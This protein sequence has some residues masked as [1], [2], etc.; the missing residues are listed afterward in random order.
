[1]RIK[2][3]TKDIITVLV[4][5]LIGV[6]FLAYFKIKH[7]ITFINLDEL[8]WMY[9]SR[10]FMDDI[11]KFDFSNLIQFPQPGI[12]VMWLAGPFMK[13]LDYDFSLISNF[14]ESFYKAGVPYNVIND[15][16]PELYL[17]YKEISFLFNIPILGLIFIFI[18]SLYYLLRK[19]DFNKW[20]VIFSLFLIAT[21]PYYI[22]FT[23]PTDKLVGIFSTLSLLGLLVYTSGKGGRRFLLLSAILCSWAALTK[24]S[25]LFLV[26]FSFLVLAFYKSGF[27]HF[28]VGTR[29][30]L[31]P[32]TSFSPQVLYFK[33]VI[34]DYLLWLIV[35]LA[36]S[37]IFLP[38]IITDPRSILNFF[39]KESSQ[40][41]IAANPASYDAFLN[42]KIILAYL[43]DS[44]VLSFNLLAII[45][46]IA[47]LC[48]IVQRTKRK[49]TVKRELLVFTTYFFTF[50]LFVTLFSKAMYSFR[51]LVPILIIFQIMAGEGIYEFSNIIIKRNKIK[52]KN[53]V[54]LW[55]IAFIL[56]SQGLLIYYSEIQKIENLPSF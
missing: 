27:A 3:K 43:S 36:V 9:G 39:S 42:F 30:C 1:M 25:A 6:L 49:I 17:E 28:S 51:Y 48:L 37:I 26:P 10:F 44:F 50:F 53:A 34:K 38:T 46:F 18:S 56:I 20:A 4:I 24:L 22:Y 16:N 14:I 40:R 41:I 29:H 19:L 21:T 7:S 32:T 11:L 31:I 8:L 12:M 13:I 47:F 45:L 52:N 2:E 54:Y 55:V 23:T 33:N 35:F 5:M 15:W